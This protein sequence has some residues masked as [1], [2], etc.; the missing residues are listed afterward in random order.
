M[1][2]LPHPPAGLFVCGHTHGG[3]IATPWG[4]P[5]VPGRM[6]KM[7]P[8][9]LHLVEGVHLHVSRGVGGIE[10]PVRAYAKPEVAVFELRAR[11]T[12]TAP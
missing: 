5:F 6:G 11:Q 8:H 9:G 4:P 10:L 3:H 2:R 7:Y 12:M 1:K